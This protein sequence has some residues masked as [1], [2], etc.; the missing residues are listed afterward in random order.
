[1]GMGVGG[2]GK[3]GRNHVPPPAVNVTPLVDVA[4][5]VLIIFMVVT[6]L[7]A[8]QMWMNLPKQDEKDEVVPPS[9][10]ANKPLVMTVD[11][12]GVVRVNQTVIAK[13]DIA[14]RLP[15]MLAAKRHKTLYF[16]AHDELAYGKAVE[17]MDLSRAGGARSI[18]ILTEKVVK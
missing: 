2:G 11:K 9:D 7:I 16:D 5:V 14:A 12:A 1:M 4:L 8:K 3:V 6:P 10:E 13:R 15:R 17:V 18:A